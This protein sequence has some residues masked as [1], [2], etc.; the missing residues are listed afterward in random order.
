MKKTLI[1]LIAFC[2]LSVLASSAFAAGTKVKMAFATWVGYGPLYIAKEKGFF[3]KHGLDVDLI[4]IDDEAQYAAAMVSGNIDALG[5]VLDREVIHFAKGAPETV[6][7]AM[8]ES[9]GADGI[10][11][12]REIK[13]VSD[14]KG[15]AIGLDKSSSSYFFLLT[16]L[17]KAGL[18][19][20]DVTIHEM[21]ASD[22][23]TAFIAGRLD[24]AITWEPWLSKVS[25]REGGHVLASSKEFPRTIVDIVTMRNDFIAEHPE[26]PEAMTRAWFEAIE[27]YRS[28][29]NEGNAIMAK[30]LGET[31]ESVAEMAAGVSF[32]DK[33][34]NLAFFDKS[35]DSNI[36]EVAERARTFWSAKGIITKPVDVNA[37]VT[38]KYVTGAAE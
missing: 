27:W 3:E 31:A 1:A 16:A 26:A 33:A 22:A 13:A 35:T 7:F 32:F 5:N 21:E 14:L 24:A 38:D 12:V 19:E 25:T 20:K 28:N 9:A 34:G 36:F 11:A 6:L 29:P 17:Q 2:C 15:Q 18:E 4:I 23:G 30:H 37:L 10:I 8:D